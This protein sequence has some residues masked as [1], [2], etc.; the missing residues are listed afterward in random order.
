MRC[1]PEI[2]LRS[3]LHV[4]MPVFLTIRKQREKE[5]R[6]RRSWSRLKEGREREE[7]RK[8]V[9]RCERKTSK[10]LPSFDQAVQETSGRNI[11][12]DFNRAEQEGS[13]PGRRARRV[14]FLSGRPKRRE[15]VHECESTIYVL[16]ERTFCSWKKESIRK[17]G[18]GRRSVRAEPAL[19]RS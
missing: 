11:R 19:L 6:R 13:D 16:I 14:S 18:E 12:A 8:L 7:G 10:Q 3:L 9:G 17:E 4:E 5:R 2:R 1:L 15:N